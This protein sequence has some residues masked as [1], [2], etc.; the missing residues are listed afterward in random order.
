[1]KAWRDGI[2]LWTLVECILLVEKNK[3]KQGLNKKLA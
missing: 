1:M 2:Q 3:K